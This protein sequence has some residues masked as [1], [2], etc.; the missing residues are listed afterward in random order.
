MKETRVRN[1]IGAVLYGLTVLLMFLAIIPIIIA[2]VPD[3]IPAIDE[4]VSANASLKFVALAVITFIIGS[5]LRKDG[6]AEDFIDKM[7]KALG[8]LKAVSVVKELF[9][10]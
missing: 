7:P 8:A 3:P 9:A 10:K 5:C 1:I 6:C 4:I 2:M